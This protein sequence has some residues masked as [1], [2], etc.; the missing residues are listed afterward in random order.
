M[1]CMKLA[2]SE[3]FNPI[4]SFFSFLLRFP[5]TKFTTHISDVILEL[6]MLQPDYTL[7]LISP[8]SS[9]I[10]AQFPE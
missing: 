9:S 4:E 7:L 3:I 10:F 5:F 1:C 8:R 2:S 6:L